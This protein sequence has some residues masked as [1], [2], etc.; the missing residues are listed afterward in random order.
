VTDKKLE[1]G[2]VDV[3]G[4]VSLRGHEPYYDRRVR[5]QSGTRVDRWRCR[6]DGCQAVLLR[7]IHGGYD[8]AMLLRSCGPFLPVR[9]SET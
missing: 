1:I 6:G 5:L 4:E 3:A 2:D 7:Y 8:G 9:R